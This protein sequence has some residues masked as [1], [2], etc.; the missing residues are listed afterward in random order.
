MQPVATAR[1][2]APVRGAGSVGPRERVARSVGRAS[3]SRDARAFR[4]NPA[5]ARA[6][7]PRS[8]VGTPAPEVA[9]RLTRAALAASVSAALAHTAPAF[10]AAPPPTY[11]GV[12]PDKSELVQSASRRVSSEPPAF[13][14]F[15]PR[16]RPSARLTPPPPSDPFPVQSSSPNP[17][18][19]RRRT[20]S[21]AWIT[22]TTAATTSTSSPGRRSSPSRAT[23]G[24]RS[25]DTSAALDSRGSRRNEPIRSIR[26]HRNT[27]QGGG[28][29]WASTISTSR[30]RRIS[31]RRGAR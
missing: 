31:P 28:R 5:P 7:R 16:A 19:T 4:R 29:C 12:D 6:S 15:P 23:R 1:G 13:A 27:L 14:P 10:A 22:S 8:D 11:S 25:L 2:C 26:G 24:T 20:T 9:S 30:R 21:N 18:K 3:S 17:G